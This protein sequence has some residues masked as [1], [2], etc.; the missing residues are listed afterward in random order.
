MGN[1]DTKD[2]PPFGGEGGDSSDSTDEE[3]THP[4][5]AEMEDFDS[6]SSKESTQ[7]PSST[8]SGGGGGGGGTGAGIAPV[9]DTPASQESNHSDSPDGEEDADE[10]EPDDAKPT[11][12]VELPDR[13]VET[14]PGNHSDEDVKD[15]KDEEDD[16]DDEDE[17]HD[18]SIVQYADPWSNMAW[19]VE[20]IMKR[21]SEVYGDEVDISYELVPVRTFDDPDEM[22]SMW[23][24]DARL[25][26]MPVN[27]SIWSDNPPESTERANRA[28]ATAQKQGTEVAR[29]YLRRLRIAGLVE[30][31]NIEDRDVLL[32]LADEV[33]LDTNRFERD[34]AETIVNTNGDVPNIPRTQTTI[35]GFTFT[36]NGY[37]DFDDFETYFLNIDLEQ[38]D[39]Q[40]LIGFIQEYGP[41]ATKEVMEVYGHETREEAVETLHQTA[42][43]VPVK[44]G[45]ST[46]WTTSR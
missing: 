20:P 2:D 45:E 34:W 21:I 16:E 8:P 40:P 39:P 38:Q 1:R 12:E 31:Q 7:S 15:E 6:A 30:G 5:Q 14:E 10:K 44:L 35:D 13:E 32:E 18:V 27:T 26:G 46:F 29:E 3:E 22:R 25:H 17:D 11:P 23:E 24:E 28:Y 33:G 43:I 4:D 42:G 41:V 9:P 36:W 37:L 19:G